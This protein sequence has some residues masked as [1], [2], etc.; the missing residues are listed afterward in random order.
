MLLSCLLEYSNCVWSMLDLRCNG[1]DTVSGLHL[2]KPS[3][4]FLWYPT[5][6]QHTLT[7]GQSDNLSYQFTVA[8][9]WLETCC[10]G[11][12]LT[13][14]FRIINMDG[15]AY[16]SLACHF[17]LEKKRL[18]DFEM[19]VGCCRDWLCASPTVL[20]HAPQRCTDLDPADCVFSGLTGNAVGGCESV[21]SAMLK[22][23]N[24]S[25]AQHCNGNRISQ[26]CKNM[27]PFDVHWNL[28]LCLCKTRR[29]HKWNR[30]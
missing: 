27:P 23:D 11:E 18:M 22:R 30:C 5:A 20:F 6:A 13:K 2:N 1:T 8:N 17:V 4:L 14:D 29:I 28:L 15:E 21:C 10:S 3:T 26:L 24:E 12:I 16:Q 25:K 7:C 19:S 9:V